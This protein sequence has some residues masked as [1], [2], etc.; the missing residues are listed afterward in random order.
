MQNP[1]SPNE[2]PLTLISVE[3]VLFNV[4]ILYVFSI[5]SIDTCFDGVWKLLPEGG[6]FSHNGISEEKIKQK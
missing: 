2:I 4:T 6:F 3:K 1:F 5:R